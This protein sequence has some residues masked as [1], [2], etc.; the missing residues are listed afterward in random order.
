MRR[1]QVGSGRGWRAVIVLSAVVMMG[2]AVVE[3]Q[4]ATAMLGGTVRDASGAPVAGA[5]VV[6]SS[7]TTGLT[8]SAVTNQV[9]AY[10]LNQLPPGTYSVE[11]TLSGFSPRTVS[12]LVLEVG[13]WRTLD[14][15]L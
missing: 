10:V 13:Q 14:L 1:G 5:S 15:S 6:L 11:V 12:E 8:R 7:R 2:S 3:A 4:S 9:G